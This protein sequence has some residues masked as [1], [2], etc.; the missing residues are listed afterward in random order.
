[1]ID[2]KVEIEAIAYAPIDSKL[3]MRIFTASLAT[4]TNTFSPVPTDRASF[5]MAFYAPPGQASGNADAVLLA[6]GGAAPPGAKADALDGDR[7]HSDL[8]GA[9]RPAAAAGL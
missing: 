3:A 7:R 8:G 6:D 1:M 2:I 4:E 5:E 9:R